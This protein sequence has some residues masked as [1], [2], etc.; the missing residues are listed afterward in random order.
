MAD[1]DLALKAYRLYH[2][3]KQKIVITKD[4]FF[5]ESEMAMIW[6]SQ[7][8]VPS[9]QDIIYSLK[10]TNS[11]DQTIVAEPTK[12]TSAEEQV[13]Q[14]QCKKDPP[15]QERSKTRQHIMEPPIDIEPATASSSINTTRMDMRNQQHP[16][17]IQKLT[18]LWSAP[19][20]T[21]DYVFVLAPTPE[22]KDF[23]LANQHPGWR[24]AM[25][26]DYDS[27]IFN[28][29]WSLKPLRVG[30]RPVTSK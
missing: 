23:E 1:Y 13:S 20:T 26:E 14:Q 30:K 11:D 15:L 12:F 9:I 6:H 21:K 16:V 2:L 18:R 4:A 8:T 24:Q 10:F 5:D 19:I 25:K 7:T 28:G 29:T 3:N 17:A 27:L 22:P